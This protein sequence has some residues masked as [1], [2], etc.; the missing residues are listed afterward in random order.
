MTK[1]E[2]IRRW[3]ELKMEHTYMRDNNNNYGCFNIEACR[4][5]NYVYNSR[6][7]I[8]CHAS[9]GLIDCVQCVDCRNCTYCVGLTGSVFAICN[10]EYPEEEYYRI[11]AEMGVNPNVDVGF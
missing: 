3:E 7:A 11:L 9:D 6:N 8:S 10:V 5:C 1:N 4:N 2:A